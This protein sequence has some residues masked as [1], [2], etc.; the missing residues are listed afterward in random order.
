MTVMKAKSS[1]EP[2]KVNTEDA[3]RLYRKRLRFAAIVGGLIW[4]VLVAAYVASFGFELSGRQDVWGQFGDYVGGL[5]NPV[6]GFAGF[7]I[8]LGTLHEQ[9][10]QIEEGR[11]RLKNEQEGERRRLEEERKRWQE[12]QDAQQQRLEEERQRFAEEHR[13]R[14]RQAFE[15]TFFRLLNR[16]SEV[17]NNV[18]YSEID[19]W[20]T[21]PGKP[22]QR[23]ELRGRAALEKMYEILRKNYKRVKRTQKISVRELY[24]YLYTGTFKDSEP[25]LGIYFRTLYHVFKF[26]DTSSLTFDERIG[27]ANIARAQLSGYE[28]A[29]VFYNGLFGEG[30]TGFRPLINKYGILKHVKASELLSPDD[31]ADRSLYPEEAMAKASRRLEIFGGVEPQVSYD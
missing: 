19:L 12:Q 1:Q 3:R 11:Q 10:L 24:V 16:F 5:L 14:V 13:A 23:R 26:V 17:V 6:F 18:S 15:S 28:L 30:E 2:T 31:I 7:L 20:L 27:Y 4:I 25:E 9:R 22:I 8:L 21:Q 29:F